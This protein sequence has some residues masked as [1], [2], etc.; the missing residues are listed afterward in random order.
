LK[1]SAN[2]QEMPVKKRG[3][4]KPGQSGNP[5]GKP[6]GTK[7]KFPSALK[8][9]VLHA[10]AILEAKGLDLASQAVKDPPWFYANFVK[11]MLPK[12]IDFTGQM[13]IEIIIR[14]LVREK[15]GVDK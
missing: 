15:I 7:N 8:D 6:P 1:N 9:K 5:A 2:N 4:F 14:D 12:E 10:C 3:N 11:P 13:G